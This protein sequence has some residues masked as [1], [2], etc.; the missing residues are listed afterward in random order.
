MLSDQ[1]FYISYFEDISRKVLPVFALGL[2]LEESH[3]LPVFRIP[4]GELPVDKD[5][6][7]PFLNDD[8]A[9][10]KVGVRERNAMIRSHLRA[11]SV[12]NG[13][14]ALGPRRTC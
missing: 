11:Q 14:R 5:F 7:L 1:I 4:T 10:R 9:R 3:I 6:D 12:A 13:L 8:V 2:A